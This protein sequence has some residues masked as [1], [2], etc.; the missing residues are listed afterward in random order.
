MIHR[1]IEAGLGGVLLI[2]GLGIVLG[3]ASVLF[4][5]GTV[6]RFLW[7]RRKRR[8]VRSWQRY[9]EKSRQW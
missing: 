7:E 2:I 1:L 4:L 6:E 3:A 9:A 8:S 5:W